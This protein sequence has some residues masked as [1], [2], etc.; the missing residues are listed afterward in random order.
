[1]TL[2]SNIILPL[3]TDYP[4]ED[5]DRYLRDLI[6]QIQNFYENISENVNGFIRN[7]A[8][9]DQAVWIPTIAGSSSSGSTTYT[10]QA[11]WS[12]RKGIFTEIFFDISWSSTSA[13]GN[14][15]VELPYIV[16]ISDGIPFVGVL[17]PSS[18]G[19][20]GGTNLVI[21]A[22][23]NSYRGYIYRTGSGIVTSQIS[24]PG[25]GRLIGNLRYIGLEDQ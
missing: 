9:I 5:M 24:V 21:N 1:M 3:R 7:N 15:Y 12:I 11:G 6:Y 22:S 23:P 20:G 10:S 25:S 16:T 14:L 17:Q 4:E 8:E 19:Y 13:T 2:P 18:I